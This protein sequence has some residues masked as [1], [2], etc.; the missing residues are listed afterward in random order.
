MLYFCMLVESSLCAAFPRKS[1]GKISTGSLPN[2]SNVCDPLVSPSDS[3]E[4]LHA[5][6][7]CRVDIRNDLKRA[8]KR[9]VCVGEQNNMKKKKS[10][11]DKIKEMEMLRHCFNVMNGILEAHELFGG[12]RWK[13]V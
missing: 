13:I 4:L 5:E 11:N 3:V 2:G 7:D 1:P 9:R 6:S 10:C 8:K 12:A